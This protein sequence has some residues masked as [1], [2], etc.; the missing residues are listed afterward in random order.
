MA[1][2]LP[3]QRFSDDSLTAIAKTVRTVLGTP[4][5]P[6]ETPQDTPPPVIG[7]R[8]RLQT[9]LSPGKAAVAR[10]L[11]RIAVEG[12][13]DDEYEW[14]EGSEDTL[15]YGFGH[16]QNFIAAGAD[17]T[18]ISSPRGWYVVDAGP[19]MVL[20]SKD[21]RKDVDIETIEPYMIFPAGHFSPHFKYAWAGA[22]MQV[23]GLVPEVA[24][25]RHSFFAICGRPSRSP[26]SPATPSQSSSSTDEETY[27]TAPVVRLGTVNPVR[28]AYAPFDGVMS[29]G[30]EAPE[31]IR[32][33]I[34]TGDAPRGNGDLWGPGAN[35]K[36]TRS[37]TALEL[38]WWEIRNTDAYEAKDILTHVWDTAHPDHAEYQAD[39]S[40]QSVP[41][42]DIEARWP[43]V[44]LSFW[45]HSVE[46]GGHSSG[47]LSSE[48]APEVS[49]RF[50]IA[51]HGYWLTDDW[52]FNG[53][54]WYYRNYF[55]NPAY[56]YAPISPDGWF[57]P[58]GG[59]NHWGGYWG[60]EPPTAD[61][62]PP[63][64]VTP[65]QPLCGAVFKRN[66]YGFILWEYG[67]EVVGGG[68]D[69]DAETCVVAGPF[70][71]KYDLIDED[72]VT[73]SPTPFET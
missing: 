35:G 23:N 49:S 31:V 13:P 33:H 43:A 36:L 67:W 61:E 62:L 51:P 18:C 8:F 14:A 71:F 5:K 72:I 24:Y 73:P 66:R 70:R 34:Q 64:D 10:R 25:W 55:Y 16:S 46:C 15:V 2:T 65:P 38:F 53:Y 6:P 52:R 1:D 41:I 4:T 3:R 40:W 50:F 17:V 21:A 69:E 32:N 42:A 48:D 59:W 12:I 7:D 45:C 27:V 37:F 56:G 47:V 22:I 29:N 20:P 68:V 57:G 30:E 44:T 54:N 19:T 60:S 9:S 28:C 63:A 26:A 58:W 11:L 39:P